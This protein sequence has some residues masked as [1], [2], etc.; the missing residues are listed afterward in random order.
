MHMFNQNQTL[1][2]LMTMNNEVGY[3][4]KLQIH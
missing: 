2:L 3:I 4:F 1:A